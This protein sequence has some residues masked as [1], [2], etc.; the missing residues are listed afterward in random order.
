MDCLVVVRRCLVV[1]A[2][3]RS[4]GALTSAE[5]VV[6][7]LND[8]VLPLLAV[9]EV[10]AQTQLNGPRRLQLNEHDDPDVGA[11]EAVS[12]AQAHG[13]DAVTKTMRD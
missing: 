1:D 12:D 8:V 4:I 6:A 3:G 7:A 2:D 13:D 10:R 9:V 5:A 11:N